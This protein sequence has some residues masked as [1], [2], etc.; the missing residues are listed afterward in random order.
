MLALAIV[1]SVGVVGEAAA[2]DVAIRDVMFLAALMWLHS[3]WIPF[4]VASLPASAAR[5]FCLAA[6][7]VLLPTWGISCARWVSLGEAG[8]LA[9]SEWIC[10]GSLVPLVAVSL[11]WLASRAILAWETRKPAKLDL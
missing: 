7:A 4:L 1:L 2:P 9:P 3:L 6:F 10:V 8:L 5:W 11:G